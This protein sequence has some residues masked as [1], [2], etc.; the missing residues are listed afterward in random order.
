LGREL[1][2]D[3]KMVKFFYFIAIIYPSI[4]P[5]IV[6]GALVAFGSLWCT[7]VCGLKIKI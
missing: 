7:L 5:S 6:H 3:E 4:H 1:E 2:L